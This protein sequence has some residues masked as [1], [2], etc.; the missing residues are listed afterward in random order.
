V[1]SFCE[2]G[3]ESSIFRKGPHIS[4]PAKQLFSFSRNIFLHGVSS[5]TYLVMKFGNSFPDSDRKV[6]SSSVV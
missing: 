1:G 2:H 3:N 4:W 6:S 5:L